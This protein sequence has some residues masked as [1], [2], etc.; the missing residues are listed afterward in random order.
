[1][2]PDSKLTGKFMRAAPVADLKRVITAID[3]AR[4]EA[5]RRQRGRDEM[6]ARGEN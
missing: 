4:D 2:Q 6:R 1:M 3:D 5:V